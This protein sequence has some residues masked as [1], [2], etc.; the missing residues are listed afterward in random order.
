MY[1]TFIFQPLYNGLVILMSIPWIDVGMAV[2]LF[3]IIVRLILYPLSKSAL[4]AQVKMKEIEPEMNKIKKEYANDR[5]LQGQKMMELYKTKNIKP[6]SGILLLVIQLP[7]LFGLISIFYKIV[8]TVGQ[9][10]L[11][12]VQKTGLLYPFVQGIFVHSPSLSLLGLDLTNKSLILALL[13]GIIQFLQLHYSLASH[14]NRLASKN[15]KQPSSKSEKTSDMMANM[16]DQMKYFMPIL[17]FASVYWIIPAS[18][19]QAAAIIAVYWSVS[20][21]FTLAQELYVRKK[22]LKI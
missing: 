2:V 22:L 8:P 15:N 6:F 10:V 13:T 21:L 14:Q 20:T 18:Y 16:N 3:T 7:I 19:P 17:A 4:L 11:E 1:N 9:T 12:A 5:Q